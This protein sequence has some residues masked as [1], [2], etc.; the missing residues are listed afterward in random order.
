MQ[1]F[2]WRTGII[3]LML[4]FGI[5]IAEAR[6]T[7]VL[8]LNIEEAILLTLENH[9]ALKLERFSLQESL[10]KEKEEE[11]KYDAS[12]NSEVSLDS[13]ITPRTLGNS[14]EFL[15]IL[16]NSNQVSLG[17]TKE[18]ASGSA[19]S[20][21]ASTGFSGRNWSNRSVNQQV[22]RLGFSFTQALLKGLNPA[23]N[24]ASLSQARQ[25]TALAKSELVGF[26]AT[27]V[28]ET[29]TNI[30]E[31]I[32]AQQELK[33]VKESY[34]LIQR[35]LY[36][37]RERIKLG[38]L[39]PLEEST[40]LAEMA[41]R[42][43][44]L[45]QSQGKIQK[46]HLSLLRLLNPGP[47]HWADY[48]IEFTQPLGIPVI[49]LDSIESHVKL[50]V[51]ERPELKQTLILIEQK[52]LDVLRTKDGLLPKLDLFIRLG[53]SGYSDSFFGSFGQFFNS[54]FDL[55][56][57]VL[58][59]YP[60]GVRKESA[61]LKQSELQQKRQEQALE[62]LKQLIEM[63]IRQAFLDIQIARQQ[64]I[65]TRFTRKRQNEKLQAEQE[66]YRVGRSTAFQVAQAQRD[67]LASKIKAM[68]A[69]MDYMKSITRFYRL[70]GT[71]LKRR[72][73]HLKSD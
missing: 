55:S 56:S 14:T 53:K 63:D 6:S 47:G 36:E 43:Q 62:N 18:F 27:I 2:H 8:K 52:K 59:N 57:G 49:Q 73:I 60:L 28:A 68:S 42:E 34:N 51:Q 50:G 40:F 26:A 32:Q 45:I 41:L 30:W 48:Q 54:G 31:Y 65:A 13:N 39:A 38:K 69:L 25:L 9:P 7:R 70:E 1:V 37:V 23:V 29:E 22:T 35:Q 71:L 15:D 4:V 64:I 16:T 67:V 24:L 3:F 44:D 72:G 61:Q 5:T 17:L 19:L 33:L 10:L 21:E 46:L 58:F 12:L 11:A 66:R 20:L